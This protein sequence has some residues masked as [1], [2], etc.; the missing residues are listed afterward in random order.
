M[1]RA[2]GWLFPWLSDEGWASVWISICF[3]AVAC[4]IRST[5]IPGRWIELGEIE[6]TGTMFS[7]W[8]DECHQFERQI[9][10]NNKNAC[11]DDSQF[12][13]LRHDSVEVIGS[14]PAGGFVEGVI[15]G[16]HGEADLN[17]VLPTSST[18]HALTK[19]TSPAMAGSRTYLRPLN[20]R[21]SFLF[22]GILTPLDTPP[23]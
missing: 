21:N 9:I 4:T 1:S 15:G 13:I 3:S 19:A 6:P 5:Y 12:R 8:S 22:P 7:A 11:L 18:F 2:A 16:L 23:S 10:Y 17:T 20:S 14:I